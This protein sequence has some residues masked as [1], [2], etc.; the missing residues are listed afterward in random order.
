M[1]GFVLRKM[2]VPSHADLPYAVDAEPEMVPA[3][4][5]AR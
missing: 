1:A 4:K 3:V 2:K 5:Q